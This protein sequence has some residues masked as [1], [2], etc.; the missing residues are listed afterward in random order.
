MIWLISINYQINILN[1]GS[2][3]YIL[4]DALLKIW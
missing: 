3:E 4:S 2:L 1:T